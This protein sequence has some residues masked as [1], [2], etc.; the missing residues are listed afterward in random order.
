MS[1]PLQD[2]LQEALA[3]VGPDQL[4]AVAA[5]VAEGRVVELRKGPQDRPTWLLDS[6]PDDL[7]AGYKLWRV[8]DDRVVQGPRAALRAELERRVRDALAPFEG[9]AQ[10]PPWV[11]QCRL[12]QV[13][14]LV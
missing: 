12:A 10:V 5:G 2:A 11:Q 14:L 8:G 13:A 1:L 3:L 9:Q 4:G 6:A 7:P